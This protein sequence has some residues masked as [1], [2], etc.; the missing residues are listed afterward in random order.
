MSPAALFRIVLQWIWIDVAFFSDPE[1]ADLAL[2]AKLVEP[3]DKSIS[4]V[5]GSERVDVNVRSSLEA[6][7]DVYPPFDEDTPRHFI[8]CIDR[9]VVP[10]LV[11]GD[12][13][14]RRCMAS[15]DEVADSSELLV[16]VFVWS[17][18]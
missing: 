1:S 2:F 13:G 18:V 16:G 15:V 17:S 10:F 8:H 4:K 6:S 12:L 11:A 7:R 14:P 3:R 9:C 5:N